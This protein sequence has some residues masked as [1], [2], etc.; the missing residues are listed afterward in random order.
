MGRRRGQGP[1]RQV[2]GFRPGKEPPQLRK[3]RA[4]QQ[5]GEMNTAQERLVEF[6][7]ERS[8]DEARALMGRWRLALL[9]GAV[10]LG[11]VGA[12]LYSWSTVAGIIVH[13]LAVIVLVLWWQI[14]RQREALETMADQVGGRPG[15]RRRTK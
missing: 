12:A 10:L 15:K 13:V 1:Q 3:Q 9:L 14:R 8:P 2:K 5:F 6:F 4:K 11:V 7:A